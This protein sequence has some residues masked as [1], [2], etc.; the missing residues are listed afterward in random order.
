MKKPYCISACISNNY[1]NAVSLI[2]LTALLLLFLFSNSTLCSSPVSPSHNFKVL[3]SSQFPVS[4]VLRLLSSGYGPEDIVSDTLHNPPRILVSCAS[5]RPE[6]PFYGE[7]ESIDPVKG[8][9]L[10][11]TR[12]GE[13]AGL[14][15]RPHGISLVQAGEM[16]YL[17]VITHDDAKGIH[18]IIQYL[19]DG[20]NLVFVKLLSSKLLVSPNALQAFPDGSLLVCND[21]AERNS[22]K[23]KIFKL[24]RG[25]ILYCDGHGNW[26][27]VATNLG[28]PAGL[29][30]I[31]TRIFVSGT[32]EN[33]LYSYQFID[34]QL[35]G[36]KLVC[37]IKG[38]DNIRVNNGNLIITSHSKPFK[39]I[40]HVKDPSRK[41]PSLVISVNPR[42]GKSTRLF[43]DSGKMISAASV[44]LIFNNQLIIGQ[45]FE[46]FIGI[47]D[48]QKQNP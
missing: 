6:Y 17:F 45:I 19:L 36:K 22:M 32:L 12:I 35:T 46:P 26:T 29:T 44:A 30:G 37:N 25:N 38:P 27:I 10:V 8:S 43:Y 16:Q 4:Q 33:K 21:A 20:N 9:R 3:Q 14:L 7:I 5:R 48:I 23:E 2:R 24:K 47:I 34:G 15:F 40:G 18:P 41:S 11:M 28:M 42:T 1:A 31:G 13:P 39:F